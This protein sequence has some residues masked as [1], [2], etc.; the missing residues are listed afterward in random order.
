MTLEL[1][2]AILMVGK[3]VRKALKK[4]KIDAGVAVIFLTAEKNKEC[5]IL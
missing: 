4:K 5:T 2:P 1:V 3:Y